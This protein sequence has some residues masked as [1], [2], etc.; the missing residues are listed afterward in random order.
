MDW[1]NDPQHAPDEREGDYWCRCHEHLFCL[2]VGVNRCYCWI[3]D[4]D[5]E[6]E[7]ACEAC[8]ETVEQAIERVTKEFR[9]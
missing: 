3:S 6:Q 4:G 2:L 5:E 9:R 7:R 8:G 1:C